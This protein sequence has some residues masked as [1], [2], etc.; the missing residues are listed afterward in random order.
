ML[1]SILEAV[2]CTLDNVVKVSVSLTDIQDFAAVNE[3]YTKFFEDNYP[4]RAIFQVEKKRIFFLLSLV[5]LCQVTALPLKAKIEI[6]TLAV[7][8][9][10]VNID[11]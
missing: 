6:E 8:G 4:A 5:I 10:L 11:S 7:V 3:V 1:E 2:N 9:K